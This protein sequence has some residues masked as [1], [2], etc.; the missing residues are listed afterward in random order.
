MYVSPY[1]SAVLREVRDRQEA[2][3]LMG[4]SDLLGVPNPVKFYTLE[5]LP[6]LIDQ[7]HEWHLRMGM[8]R[9]PDGGFRCC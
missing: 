2:F 8:E 9:A 5:L 4:F 6:Y 7:H 1:R 3:F